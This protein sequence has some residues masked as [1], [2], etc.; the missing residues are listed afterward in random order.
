MK[1]A[2]FYLQVSPMLPAKFQ[3]NRPL[4]PGD[5]GKIHFQDGGHLG[6]LIG[7]I[8]A[9]FYLQV[10]HMLPTKFSG[11]LAFRFKRRSEK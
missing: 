9:L 4:E 3:L 6:V 5:K 10:T 2:F 7:M 11:Q 1:S 8:L